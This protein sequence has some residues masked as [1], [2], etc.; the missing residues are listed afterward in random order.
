MRLG[1]PVARARLEEHVVPVHA[2][3]VAD[4][5]RDGRTAA[6][7]VIGLEAEN[8]LREGREIDRGSDQVG[9]VRDESV[10]VAVDDRVR[11]A[12]PGQVAGELAARIRALDD[13]PGQTAVG[14]VVLDGPAGRDRAAAEVL[15]E[16]VEVG[17]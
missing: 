13:D 17:E 10:A 1:S 6:I 4:V 8:G 7:E 9:V 16:A 11:P 15:E 2:R 3:V 5:G 14:A 12:A